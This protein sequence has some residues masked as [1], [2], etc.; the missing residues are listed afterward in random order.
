MVAEHRGAATKHAEVLQ[1]TVLQSGTQDSGVS[2]DTAVDLPHTNTETTAQITVE[3]TGTGEGT[4][5]DPDPDLSFLSDTD[6]EEERVQRVLRVLHHRSFMRQMF[7]P[8]AYNIKLRMGLD[9]VVRI[10]GSQDSSAGIPPRFPLTADTR[11]AVSIIAE[12]LARQNIPS[13]PLHI[14]TVIL[15]GYSHHGED[16]Y[17]HRIVEY[18]CRQQCGLT[19]RPFVVFKDKIGSTLVEEVIDSADIAGLAEEMR[20]RFLIPG[21]KRMAQRAALLADQRASDRKLLNRQVALIT[22]RN[23]REFWTLSDECESEDE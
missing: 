14:A 4:N 7:M 20:D 21:E 1:S 3:N 17:G 11:K 6:D 12:A 13:D 10:Y 19:L 23:E 8:P 18:M 2:P 9:D 22:A 16:G 5:P 15:Q